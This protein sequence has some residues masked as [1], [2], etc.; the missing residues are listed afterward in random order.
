MPYL[1]LLS[2]GFSGRTF[3]GIDFV[4]D[5]SVPHLQPKGLALI[6][7]G[8]VCVCGGGGGGGGELP[9]QNGDNTED[10][11]KCL[12]FREMKL[13]RKENIDIYAELQLYVLSSNL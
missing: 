11:R 12:V 7:C 2:I 6:V 3:H 4:P 8:E 10:R 13:F 1:P 5:C 9:E